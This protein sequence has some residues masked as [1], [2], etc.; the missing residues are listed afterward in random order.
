MIPEDEVA[1]HVG[2][3]SYT[4][5]SDTY[6]SSYPNDCTLGIE[7]CVQDAEGSYRD[8]TKYSTASLC[9]DICTRYGLDPFKHI[10]THQM[11]VG[12]KKCPKWYCDHPE[13]LQYFKHVVSDIIESK[14]G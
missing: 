7:M 9:A 13:D 12:W 5:F 3:R 4:D 1:Y 11:V 10:I 6:L 2:S 8:D 14:E